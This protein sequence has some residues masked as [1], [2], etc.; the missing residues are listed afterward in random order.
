MSYANFK[1]II[2]SKAIQTALHEKTILANF[3]NRQF[4]GDARLGGVVNIIG[5]KA[6]DIFEYKPGEELRAPETQ[7]G[8]ITQ[9]K[10]DQARAFNVLI[11]D[12]DASQV[13]G[14][15]LLP[16]L[17]DDAGAKMAAAV[18]RYVAEV[19]ATT[20]GVA[21]SANLT[22]GTANKVKAAIDDA[23]LHLR[24]KNVDPSIETVIELPWWMYQMFKNELT[25]AKT[26]N[27]ALISRGV[28]GW[29][30]GF[31][32]VASNCLYNADGVDHAIVR[33]KKAIAFA[34]TIEKIEAYRP[35][36]Y[37]GDGMKGLNVF[38]ACV[39]RPDELY[40]IKAQ[41]G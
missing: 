21:A 12:I 20:Q 38:G 10:I 40:I 27:D 29:Y 1:P 41:K 17:C 8:E 24:E 11:D 36:K 19:A 28:V 26:S 15:Q 5:A 6:P 13:N 32:V 30:D 39:C 9:L 16:I 14:V 3:C 37:F 7:E 31:K 2:W 23:I 25:E 4:D 34:N 35:E 22:L 33:T 18:D